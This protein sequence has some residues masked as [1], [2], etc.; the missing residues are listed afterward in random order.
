MK[1]IIPLVSFVGGIPWSQ[2]TTSRL[3]PLHQASSEQ[4]IL[5][6]LHTGPQ[7]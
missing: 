1:G 2:P 5:G 6:W 7:L 4:S 3:C